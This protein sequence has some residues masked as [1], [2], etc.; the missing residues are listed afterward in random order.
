MITAEVEGEA[1]LERAWGRVV[2]EVRTGVVRG[3]GNGAK[4][5]AAEAR[6][7]HAFK[8]KT[9]KLEKSIHHVVIGWTSDTKYEA[10]IIAKE[11]YASF[12]EGGTESH[13]IAGRRGGSLTFEW[14]GEL[15]HFRYIMHPGTKPLPFMG[16]AYQKAERVIQREIE[17]A[18]ERAQSALDR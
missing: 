8:N 6:Q 2:A 15:V 5:G 12:V 3:V 7:R 11:Q 17:L 10:K 18:L 9:G 16:L 13:M 1:D 4:D 14:K